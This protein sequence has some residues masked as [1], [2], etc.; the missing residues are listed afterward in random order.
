MI[1]E[2]PRPTPAEL[3]PLSPTPE[4]VSARGDDP[5][6]IIQQRLRH[7]LFRYPLR[8]VGSQST[9]PRW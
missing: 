8:P 1:T 2:Q 3:L 6:A 5:A 7:G 4:V 9:E